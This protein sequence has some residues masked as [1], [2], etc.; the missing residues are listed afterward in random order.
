MTQ[1]SFCRILF[2]VRF[3]WFQARLELIQIE[4]VTQRGQVLTKTNIWWKKKRRF[5]SGHKRKPSKKNLTHFFSSFF[6][7]KKTGRSLIWFF[8]NILSQKNTASLVFIF[9]HYFSFS[10]PHRRL[11]KYKKH[12]HAKIQRPTS[13]GRGGMLH[14]SRWSAKVWSIK[15]C[16]PPMLRK[17]NAY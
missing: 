11:K 5:K 16:T 2:L 1:I 6:D 9:F 7:Y 8:R 3:C 12:S 10:Q 13:G 14:L 15:I 17:G 4:L